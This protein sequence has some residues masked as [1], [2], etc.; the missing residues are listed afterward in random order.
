MLFLEMLEFLV[1][2]IL[3]YTNNLKNN[4]LVLSEGDTF[5]ING[6]FSAPEKKLS[7]SFSKAKTNFSLSLHYN[8]NN[9]YLFVNRKEIYK[10]KA[11]NENINFLTQFSSRK[12]M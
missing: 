2:I 10:L 11:D 8:V 1:L 5:G 12:H 3:H 6:S 7:I 9:S 4:F